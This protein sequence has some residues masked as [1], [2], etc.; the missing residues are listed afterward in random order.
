MQLHQLKYILEVFRS[1]NHISAAAEV[2]HTSQPGISKQIRLLEVEIGADLLIRRGNQI[3][4]LTAVGEA[5][6]AAAR[7]TLWEAQNLQRITDEFTQKGS[8]RLIIATTHMYA[9]YVLRPVI[10]DFIHSHP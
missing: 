3:V 5:I 7:R 10:T 8:G 4:G 1:G 2:L 9:R 6:I